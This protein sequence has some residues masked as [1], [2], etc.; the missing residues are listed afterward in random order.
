MANTFLVRYGDP[1][2]FFT[3]RGE[4]GA[5]RGTFFPGL[6][7]GMAY[8]VAF[9]VAQSLRDLGFYN[10]VVCLDR[11]QTGQSRGHWYDCG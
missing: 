4:D 5:P 8:E 10:A 7:E 11:W 9:Q 3:R 2:G 6:A 1:E